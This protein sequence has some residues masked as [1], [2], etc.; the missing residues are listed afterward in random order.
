MSSKA[1]RDAEERLDDLQAEVDAL[2]D[3][4]DSARAD[5]SVLQSRLAALRA[6]GDKLADAYERYAAERPEQPQLP[7]D[8]A[9]AGWRE[10]R[11]G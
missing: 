1:E 6:A 3:A 8:V 9:L 4:V 5:R 11:R 7:V 10:A 2:R